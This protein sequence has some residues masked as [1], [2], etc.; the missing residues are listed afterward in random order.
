[1]ECIKKESTPICSEMSSLV[2]YHED[3]IMLMSQLRSCCKK[4]TLKSKIHTVCYMKIRV[5]ASIL[6]HETKSLRVRASAES[7]LKLSDFQY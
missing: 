5:W 4:C 7:F 2:I 3:I 6:L 1:M